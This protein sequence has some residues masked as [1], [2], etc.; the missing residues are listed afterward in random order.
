MGYGGGGGFTPS[1]NNIEGE[2]RA[3]GSNIQLSSSELGL[4]GI[5]SG[6]VAGP[7]SYLGLTTTG[8]IVFSTPAGGGG[9]SGDV[10][11]GSTFTTAGVI[12]AC[13]GDDKTI[14]EPGTTLTT[15]NQGLT[16]SGVTKVGASAGSGQDLFA[17][18]AGAA[19]HVGLQW[20]ANGE[21][22]GILI[23]GAD[24][25]GVDFK[26]HGE[27][28]GKY[29]HWDM[30]ADAL[31]L[32]GLLSSS[33]DAQIKGNVVTEGTLKTSGSV[34]LG[35]A[36]ADVTT[37]T[38]QLTASQGAQF[39]GRVGIGTNEPAFDLHIKNDSS[40]ALIDIQPAASNDSIIRFWNGTSVP[41]QMQ[42]DAAA[43]GKPNNRFVLRDALT[44]AYNSL[45]IEQDI[46]AGQLY[47]ASG[48]DNS[49]SAADGSRLGINT[50]G[51]TE[52]LSVNGTL[53]VTGS[54]V[55]KSTISGSGDAHF[56]GAVTCGAT[57]LTTGSIG[58]AG[59]SISN[60]D[61]G[62]SNTILGSAAG[63]AVASG[64]NNNVLIG[65]E[66]GNDLNAGDNNVFIGYQAGDV[67]TA[68]GDC[69][70]I[71]S[72]AGGAVMTTDADGSVFIGKSAGAAIT[73]G[74]DNIAIGK[75]ALKSEDDGDGSIAIGFMALGDQTG[76][77][78]DVLNTAIGTKAG[79]DLLTGVKNVFIGHQAGFATTNV[80]ETVIIGQGA[81]QADMTSDADGTIA[82]G[83]GAGAA[84]TS[85]IGNTCVG[86]ASLDTEDDGDQNTAFGYK[87]LSVQTGVTG[88][89]GNT[90]IGYQAGQ[91][92]TTATGCTLVGNQAGQGTGGAKLT[93]NNN[94]ALGSDAGLLLQGAA[95]SNTYIGAAAGDVTTTGVENTCLGFNCDIQDATAT[96]QIVIGNNLTGTK[97]AAVFIGNDTSHIE[98]DYNTDATW[99][100]SS[101]V[102]QKTDIR[103]DALGLA[104]INRLRP[105]TY[106]HKS[107]SEF[108]EEW[109][110]YDPEDTNP[111]GGTKRIHGFIAQEIKEA[112]NQ[113]G[114]ET[115]GGWSVGPDGR[116]RISFEALV[117]PL[118]NAVKQLS[119]KVQ[120]LENI[121]DSE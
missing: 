108:P 74:E 76:V 79:K 45:V 47:F 109:A 80:D 22:E 118:V 48:S 34:T 97:D 23:G 35:D 99:T 1:N 89:V 59:L 14:D 119:D 4:S 41:W 63:A 117:M 77:T 61:E 57:L 96:N 49:L 18:T 84:I 7:G 113:E 81:G 11:A 103:N 53:G 2:F 40:L 50:E 68:A 121:L 100:H 112:L 3:S 16:V 29:V 107:P 30:S 62:T 8:R 88:E 67:T 51:P 9:G 39:S 56:V 65:H 85:G 20:D 27:T 94:T 15:N 60:N 93:G 10:E 110:A 52:K 71:G 37:V 116:Q 32:K 69:V 82:I 5:L 28:A 55:F 98:N 105:V 21:T 26:F 101:D 25:H 92:I 90:A 83:A 91:F 114:C 95:H 43:T 44:V 17:Y 36:V 54:A 6:T 19:A 72:L 104:F 33:G 75:N 102:R 106:L 64:C 13:D 86:Y 70:V 24:D 42:N 111:M 12:M 31:V 120:E 38:G 58:G 115:F 66:A 46:G 78:G 73:S 87:T